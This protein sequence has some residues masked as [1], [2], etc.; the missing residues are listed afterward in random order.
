MMN[1]KRILVPTDFSETSDAAVKYGVGLARALSAQ[2][3]LLHVTGETGVNFE[4]DFAMV[5]FENAPRE[6][7]ETLVSEQEASQLRPEYALRLGVPSDQIVRYADDRDIDLIV[8]GTHGR[9]GLPHMM[10]GS[11]AEKVVRVAPCPV[12]TI[13]QPQ[14]A[15]ITPDGATAQARPE[16]KQAIAAGAAS[17]LHKVSRIRGTDVHAV[18]G[19]VGRVEEFYFDDEQWRIRYLVINTES[20]LSR[21]PVLISTEAV[22]P[23][24]G[25]AGFKLTLTREQVRSSPEIDLQRAVSRQDEERVLGHFGHPVYW[26]ANGHSGST[27]NL[28]ST[29]EVIGDHIQASDGAIG[30]VDDFLIDERSWRVDYLVVDTS[31]WIGGKWVLIAPTTLKGINWADSKLNVGLTREAVKHSPSI[32]SVPITPGEDGPPFIIM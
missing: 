4:A 2:L 13:R 16:R 24:W 30:H 20:W 18:D 8:M 21:H 6:Q 19:Y 9:S 3:Y 5:P 17:R 1:V 12:L 23:D 25:L 7:L 14:H 27:P 26:N 32:N 29:K 28:C 22:K 15:S 31:N 11:I 10:M